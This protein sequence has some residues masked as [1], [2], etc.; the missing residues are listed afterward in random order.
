MAKALYSAENLYLSMRIRHA[1][2]CFGFACGIINGYCRYQRKKLIIFIN[3]FHK[4]LHGAGYRFQIG[5][6]INAAVAPFPL[7]EAVFI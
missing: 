1:P 2:P 5:F 4:I 7:K 3:E 6:E